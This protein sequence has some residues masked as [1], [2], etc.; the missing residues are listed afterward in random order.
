M[1]TQLGLL[2]TYVLCCRLCYILVITSME[3]MPCIYLS[4]R[5]LV[6]V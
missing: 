3:A 6:S 4:Y 5:N 1:T 2:H